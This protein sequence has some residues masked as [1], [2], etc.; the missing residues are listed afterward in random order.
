MRYVFFG[1]THLKHKKIKVTFG[2]Y[3][4]Y[5]ARKIIFYSYVKEFEDFINEHHFFMDFFEKYPLAAYVVIKSFCNVKFSAKERFDHI[6]SDLA[7]MEKLYRDKNIC[8]WREPVEICHIKNEDEISYH[9]LLEKNPETSEEGFWAIVLKNKNGTRIYHASFTI[10]PDN[11]LLIAS[12]Q[13]S[14]ELGGGNQL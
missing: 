6:S 13:G 5:Y 11:H 8:L 3:L 7:L 14:R 1:P 10:T 9:L 2:R 12:I 4:R